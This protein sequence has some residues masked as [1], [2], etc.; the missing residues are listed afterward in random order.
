LSYFQ[1]PSESV[2][3]SRVVLHTPNEKQFHDGCGG[4][5]SEEHSALRKRISQKEYFAER[6]EALQL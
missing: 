5:L 6:K 2:L 3:G 1:T 4:D